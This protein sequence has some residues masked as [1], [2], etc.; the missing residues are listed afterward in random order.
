MVDYRI[1]IT[2][3]EGA[4][5]LPI[6]FNDAG[7]LDF[8]GLRSASEMLGKASNVLHAHLFTG[9]E[10]EDTMRVLFCRSDEEP[11]LPDGD[12]LGSWTDD[13]PEGEGHAWTTNAPYRGGSRTGDWSPAW[14][15]S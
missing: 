14:R 6:L 11:A 4:K 15:L 13:V 7:N 2:T 1:E 9:G 8:E 10:P 12:N 5:L 3:D